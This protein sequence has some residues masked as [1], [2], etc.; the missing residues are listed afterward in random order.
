MTYYILRESVVFY[1]QYLPSYVSKQNVGQVV[2]QDWNIGNNFYLKK[3]TKTKLRV[4]T[5]ETDI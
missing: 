1:E 2:T 3:T 4:T 5:R